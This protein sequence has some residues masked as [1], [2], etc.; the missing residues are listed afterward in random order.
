MIDVAEKND[1]ATAYLRV[2][3]KGS[4]WMLAVTKPCRR[5]GVLPGDTVKVTIT[6]VRDEDAD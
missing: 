5:I 1:T 2:L 6:V 4:S 3:D